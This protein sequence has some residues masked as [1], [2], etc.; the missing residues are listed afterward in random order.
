MRKAFKPV[1]GPLSAKED[2]EAKQW[3]IAGWYVLSRRARSM[4]NRE[5]FESF[6]HASKFPK[7]SIHPIVL[8]ES[9]ADFIRG[10]YESA[11][12]KATKSIEVRVR[13]LGGEAFA[14][15]IGVDLMR[16]AF[17]P[18]DGPL[19]AKEDPEAE[20]QATQS[21]FAGVIGRFKNPT[22]HRRVDFEPNEAVEVLQF[23]SY[24]HRELDWG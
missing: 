7:T 21:L 20:Q 1:D 3:S 9:Y 11:I 19:S 17:K 13:D 18:V 5:D 14:Q 8:Q 4:K 15:K 23:L 2:P 24:L 16:K 10:D 12:F 22:S 6:R